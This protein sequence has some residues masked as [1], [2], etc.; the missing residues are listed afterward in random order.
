MVLRRFSQ[1][2]CDLSVEPAF[3][4]RVATHQF[5][6]RII[7]PAADLVARRVDVVVEHRQRLAFGGVGFAAGR[8]DQLVEILADEA[9]VVPFC[10][11]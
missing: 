2:H 1:N 4:Q 3:R 5:A 6:V 11:R 10:L 9:R 8:E 7:H